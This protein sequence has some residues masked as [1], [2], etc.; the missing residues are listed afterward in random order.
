[1]LIQRKPSITSASLDLKQPQTQHW[2]QQFT[3]P[4]IQDLKLYVTVDVR[5]YVIHTGYQ[6]LFRQGHQGG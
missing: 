2:C 6:V 5:L 1:M 4:N 3:I